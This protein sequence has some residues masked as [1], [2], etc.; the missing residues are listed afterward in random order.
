MFHRLSEL[1]IVVEESALIY[2]YKRNIPSLFSICN[3]YFQ[4]LRR[5]W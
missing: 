2:V 3:A 4:Y 1:V 5:L